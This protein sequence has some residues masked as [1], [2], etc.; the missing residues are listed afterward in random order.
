MSGDKYEE[1][2]P[3]SGRYMKYTGGKISD[4]LIYPCPE[5]AGLGIHLTI[6]LD[7]QAKFGPD[8]DWSVNSD[9]DYSFGF[10]KD[11]R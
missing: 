2:I 3:F 11:G 9:Q 4:R 7:G 1:M 8:V 10:D 5:E 6:G